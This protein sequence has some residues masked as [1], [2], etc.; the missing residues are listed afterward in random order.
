[1]QKSSES[2]WFKSESQ[3]GC[4][5]ESIALSVECDI[6][7]VQNEEVNFLNDMMGVAVKAEPSIKIGEENPHG[8]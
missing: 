6:P 7:K 1:M 4:G 3:K 8:V 5:C 2:Q